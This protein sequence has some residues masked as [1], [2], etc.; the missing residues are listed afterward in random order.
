MFKRVLPRMDTRKLS[1][2][3]TIVTFIL[4][5]S[6][7]SMAP[8]S[9]KAKVLVTGARIHGANGIMFDSQDR[10]HIASVV[11]REIVIMNPRSGQIIERLGPE[12]GV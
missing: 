12:D 3:F 10:L 6:V 8:A 4:L 5:M 1:T 11:G 7:A 9:H 2:R